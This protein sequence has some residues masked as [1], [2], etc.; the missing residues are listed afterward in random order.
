MQNGPVSGA[1]S[2]LC[3]LSPTD[4][5]SVIITLSQPM[6]ERSIAI[7]KLISSHIL[8]I[9]VLLVMSGSFLHYGFLFLIITQTVL[10]ILYFAG[11]WEFSGPG[12]RRIFC[13]GIELILLVK[14]AFVFITGISLPSNIYMTG[15][16]SLA[17]MYLLF[18]LVRILIVI[19]KKDPLSVEIGFPFRNGSYLLTDGGNSRISRLMNY[20]Y[21]S[22]VHRKNGTNL[23]MLHATDIVKTDGDPCWFPPLNED[24]PVF[25]ENIY[26]PLQGVVVKT[27]DNIPDNQPWSGNYPYNTGNTVVIRKDNDYLLMGHLKNGS[28]RVMEGDIVQT[29]DLVASAG[30]S[31]YTERP[32]LHMQLIRS[33]SENYWKGTG[34]C[35]TFRNR[36]LYKNRLITV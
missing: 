4:I 34:I 21:Y 14:F 19:Y 5:A 31:G 15:I 28:I 27:V 13:L 7:L 3:S 22:A 8:L 33:E 2:P 11:Y 25:N 23:S 1:A 30:N 18:L 29:G 9:L 32:H 6:N 26:S 36:N 12:F 16:F 24:Y 35:I 17:E 10:P 20:H